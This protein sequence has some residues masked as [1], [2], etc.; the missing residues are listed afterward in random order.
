MSDEQAAT[1]RRRIEA[2]EN[3]VR[4]L[5]QEVRSL[6]GEIEKHHGRPVAAKLEAADPPFASLA[7]GASAAEA[8]RSAP[9]APRPAADAP[10]PPISPAHREAITPRATLSL[11]QLVGRYG[12]V[13]VAT[14]AILL[15]LGAFLQ[16]AIARG[17]LGPEMRVALGAVAGVVLAVVG[18]RMRARGAERF[19]NV[20]LAIAL[21]VA[22]L[23]AWAAGPS[24]QLVHPYVS[25]AVAAAASVALAGLALR[26][27]HEFLFALGLGGALLAPF[28]TSVGTGN[29]TQ[30][31]I[32]GWLVMAGAILVIRDA[33]WALSR[34]LVAGFLGVYVTAGID[35]IGRRADL[36]AQ[37]RPAA[38]AIVVALTAVLLGSPTTRRL[39]ARA[40]LGIAVV[41]LL[42]IGARHE[43]W[44]TVAY[45]AFGTL[46]VLAMVRRDPAD[47]AEGGRSI[48][49]L[50]LPLGFLFAA[51]V[52]GE[53]WDEPAGGH[54]ALGWAA[55]GAAVTLAGSRRSRGRYA[56]IALVAAQLAIV[57]YLNDKDIAAGLLTA[58]LAA[59]A[60]FV[61]ARL[62]S[63]APA[64]AVALSI[65]MAT[66]YA[67]DGL[68]RRIAYDYRPFIESPSLVA[69]AAV[70]A[71][72]AVGRS[73]PLG[74]GRGA[75]AVAAGP[76]SAAGPLAAFLWI[77]FELAEAFARDTATFLL[78]TYYAV[79]GVVTI[80]VGRRREWPEVRHVGLGLALYAA[81]KAVMEASDLRQVGLRVGSYLVVGIFLLGVGYW[82]RGERS[83]PPNADRY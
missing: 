18:L 77:R 15:G 14:L 11:E 58:A 83:S 34:W 66:A 78:I 54:V 13:V 30:L 60:A 73:A 50:L 80:G 24:L 63:R 69:L 76:W 12:T 19:G 35:D 44:V 23:V 79:A 9:E 55:F 8:P 59:G 21:A 67:Y 40:A 43:S 72:F 22:H 41:A 64:F 33:E 74:F 5:V 45:A 61:F 2:L 39:F 10:P 31:L 16:W 38:L 25:L 37:Y 4:A 17:L 6:R 53:R 62:E 28:V 70:L 56:T 36:L 65:L 46:T 27:G 29:A 26:D 1:D 51:W 3:V 57:A 75:R 82:Y 47:D 81:V 71:W 32:Y 20:L 68:E 52:T 49:E 42:A 7:G 48:D